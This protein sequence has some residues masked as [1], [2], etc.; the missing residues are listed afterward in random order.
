MKSFKHFWAFGLTCAL[1]GALTI[2]QSASAGGKEISKGALSGVEQSMIE[3]I[4]A[5]PIK[6]TGGNVASKGSYSC[7]TCSSDAWGWYEGSSTSIL[8]CEDSYRNNKRYKYEYT[9]AVV[10]ISH[11]DDNAGEYHSQVIELDPKDVVYDRGVLT[12]TGPGVDITCT[13]ETDGFGY[14]HSSKSRWQYSDGY[15]SQ[16]R[17]N[18]T[19]SS[20][21][22]T[23]VTH[24]YIEGGY[25]NE[26]IHT[27]E[28]DGN[29]LC[30]G[31][32]LGV[33]GKG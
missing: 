20:A 8:R 5:K 24:P 33:G 21:T 29:S 31:D 12:A 2:P 27:S 17:H 9:A 15:Q 19:R 30:K 4:K 11:W 6:E 7:I 10:F 26:D 14:K 28:Y 13:T 3:E 32:C 1:V 25:L 22:V 16:S 18:S 23:G